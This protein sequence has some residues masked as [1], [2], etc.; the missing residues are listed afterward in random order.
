MQVSGL[1]ANLSV[2]D[3]EAAREFYTDYL[4]LSLEGFNLG[5]VARYQSLDGAT[6]VQ[7][8]TRDATAPEDS[9]V[10]VFVGSDI[11]EAYEEAKRRGFEIVYPLT[12]EPWGL[13]RFFVRAPDGNVI[14]MT[15]HSDE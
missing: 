15:N 1:V 12:T 5:W 10:S 6:K 7:L 14:N 13:R 9:V 2:D 4:G 8:V 3:I 11:E